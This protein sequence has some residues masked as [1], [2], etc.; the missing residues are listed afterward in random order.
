MSPLV[1]PV[2]VPEQPET[3]Y[4]REQ[5]TFQAHY[6]AAK[7]AQRQ[8][9]ADALKTLVRMLFRKRKGRGKPAPRSIQSGPA[10]D[11]QI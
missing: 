3:E 7:A 6:L 1:Y 5:R 11:P 2:Q 4:Q 9:R 10:H 8:K